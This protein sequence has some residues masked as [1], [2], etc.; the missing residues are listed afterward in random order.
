M[1]TTPKD[2]GQAT[3]RTARGDRFLSDLQDSM[4]PREGTIVGPV[5]SLV[6]SPGQRKLNRL[7]RAQRTADRMLSPSYRTGRLSSQV[8]GALSAVL[9]SRHPV[10]GLLLLSSVLWIALGAAI[11]A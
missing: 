5:L 11:I 8:R 1:T 10:L 3:E 7:R 6:L 4:R 2:S 9:S